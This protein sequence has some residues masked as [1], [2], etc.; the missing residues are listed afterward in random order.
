MS[1][2]V[3]ILVCAVRTEP[4]ACTA[5]TAI[6]VTQG[7]RAYSELMCGKLGQGVLAGTA[8][9]PRAGLEYVK[10]TCARENLAPITESH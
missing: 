3:L 6:D 1:I 2:R 8:I 4:S 7:P 9:A 5:E 10:I